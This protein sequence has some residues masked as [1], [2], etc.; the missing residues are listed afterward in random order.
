MK[1]FDRP[2]Y[3]LLALAL[4]LAIWP[5]WTAIRNGHR[6]GITRANFERIKPGMSE[7]EVGAV[8]GQ[9]GMLTLM[10]WFGEA[11]GFD[12]TRD[13]EETGPS[14]PWELE[15]VLVTVDFE[16]DQVTKARLRTTKKTWAE[17]L[18]GCR[19]WVGL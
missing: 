10:S 18:R 1:R 14:P 2:R 5:S 13:Y 17:W 4:L 6:T 16:N 11:D 7:A 12:V 19:V 3:W 8:L 9:L 15:T